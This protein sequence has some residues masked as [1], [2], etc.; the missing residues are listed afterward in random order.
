MVNSKE[1]NGW[2]IKGIDDEI[3]ID[4]D[5][6][7]SSDEV[8]I[9]EKNVFVCGKCDKGYFDKEEDAEK[10]CSKESE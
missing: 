10:C 1:L 7:V 9:E 3:L 4:G 2:E 6:F 8:T 5:S